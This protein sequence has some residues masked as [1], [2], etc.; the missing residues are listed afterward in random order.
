[1]K[2]SRAIAILVL[3]VAA[4]AVRTASGTDG[5]NPPNCVARAMQW[6]PPGQKVTLICRDGSRSA[7]RVAEFDSTR[8]TLLFQPADARISRRAL[9][10]TEVLRLEW[11]ERGKP[12]ADA[13]ALGFLLGGLIGFA[14]GDA[15]RPAERHGS[16]LDFDFRSE[17]HVL[18][19]TALGAVL[20][21]GT[22]LE[23]SSASSHYDYAVDC[24]GGLENLP[25][26]PR[27]R[28]SSASGGTRH[29]SW[30]D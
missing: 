23:V 22:A 21:M 11:R 6:I 16:G 10:G 9:F 7:G 14:I 5:V 20:G 2:I 1:M 18:G 13:A 3:T 29:R 15:T 19:I 17:T 25:P 24:E 12:R 26:R 27:G 4:C 30:D 8:G 28:G